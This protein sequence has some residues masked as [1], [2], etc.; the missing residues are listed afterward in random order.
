VE[1]GKGLKNQEL[2]QARCEMSFKEVTA[3]VTG[4]GRGIGLAIANHLAARGA[5]VIISDI[6]DEIGRK[7]AAGLASEHTV[8]ATYTH[9][10]V[11]S[12]KDVIALCNKA[13]AETGR[14]DCMV[15]NAGICPPTPWQQV[16]PEE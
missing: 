6:D 4:G 15:N 10:D 16:T 2:N 14:L 13:K 12:K 9:C 11:T 7:A 8:K 1:I 5:A 3:V